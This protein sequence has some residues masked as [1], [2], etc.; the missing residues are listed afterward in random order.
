MQTTASDIRAGWRYFRSW[1]QRFQMSTRRVRCVEPKSC[2]LIYLADHNEIRLID[3]YD[4]TEFTSD[5]EEARDQKL[6][7]MEA[8]L[9]AVALESHN[10]ESEAHRLLNFQSR[11]RAPSALGF[12]FWQSDKGKFGAGA[13]PVFQGESVSVFCE[14]ADDID[15]S[16]IST[17]LPF[18]RITVR[19]P[20][21]QWNNRTSKRLVDLIIRDLAFD[22]QK[23]KVKFSLSGM[24]L[25]LQIVSPD[26][27]LK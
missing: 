27:G 25:D 21:V 9:S 14:D 20:T 1:K 13:S 10:F 2:D 23:T 19:H 4:E 3:L 12:W 11:L 7:F 5:I 18:D 6:S 15:F 24:L 8:Y 26:Y 22:G 17:I 16:D